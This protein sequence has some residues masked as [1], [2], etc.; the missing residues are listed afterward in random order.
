MSKLII[1][2]ENTPTRCEI[3]HQ[4]DLFD[5]LSNSCQRCIGTITQPSNISPAAPTEMASARAIT[6]A[7]FGIIAFIPL[8]F[9]DSLIFLSPLL[10]LAGLI[11]GRWELAA[12]QQGRANRDGE[13]FAIIGFYFGLVAITF[14]LFPALRWLLDHI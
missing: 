14:S 3:C 1:R 2:K 12:I 11:L 6:A 8:T 7:I 9:F 13:A 10:S 5:P 4:I